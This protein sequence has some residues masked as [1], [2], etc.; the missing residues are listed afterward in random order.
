MKINKQLKV[1][2]DV[3]PEVQQKQPAQEQQPNTAVSEG[4]DT[5]VSSSILPIASESPPNLISAPVPDSDP[6]NTSSCSDM[7][8]SPAV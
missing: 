2:S 8:I 3:Q 5:E 6:T 4:I 1:N 7:N